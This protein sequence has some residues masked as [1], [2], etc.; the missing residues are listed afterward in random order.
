MKKA[1]CEYCGNPTIYDEELVTET[2]R[3]IL[4]SPICKQLWRKEKCKHEFKKFFGGMWKQCTKC[5]LL[6]SKPGKPVQSIL[7]KPAKSKRKVA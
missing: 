4:C 3:L 2:P 1:K 6:L 5:K 7:T